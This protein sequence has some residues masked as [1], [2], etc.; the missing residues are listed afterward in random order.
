MLFCTR[1]ARIIY[2]AYSVSLPHARQLLARPSRRRKTLIVAIRKA[3]SPFSIEFTTG[4]C[5]CLC[6]R[7]YGCAGTRKARNREEARQA[8]RKKCRSRMQALPPFLF[9]YHQSSLS[10]SSV[11]F[12]IDVLFGVI[13]RLCNSLWRIVYIADSASWE[14]R[15]LA[16]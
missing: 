16:Q 13:K 9:L 3:L 6:A 14:T 4:K 2:R 5:V 10:S 8:S 11:S 12:V 1:E 7:I 15:P